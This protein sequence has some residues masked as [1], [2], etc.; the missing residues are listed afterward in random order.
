MRFSD[1]LNFTIVE[2]GSF[3]LKVVSII[4]IVSFF[5]I[6]KVILYF[7]KKSLVK[8]TLDE[9][10]R[11]LSLFKLFK[12]FI[13]VFIIMSVFEISGINLTFLVA[14]SA[15][16]LIGIGLGLQQTF[17][18]FVSGIIILIEGSIKVGDIVEIEGNVGKVEDINLRTSK[19]YTREL[20]SII[21]PN[22]R[23]VTDNVINWSLDSRLR[24][25]N[26]LVGVAY[27]SDVDLVMQCM[28]KSADNHPK[29]NKEILE[30][31]PKVRL[32]NF[33]N[34]SLDFEL[35]FWSTDVFSI[36]FI[37]SE[38]RLDML[39]EFG[40]LGIVI[41]FPQQDIHVID[42]KSKIDGTQ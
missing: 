40:K 35:L 33:G 32:I 16:L 41:P 28:F 20:I 29:V 10:Q 31:V 14:G 30:Y 1:I 15:A 24:R 34:S 21:V 17:N 4:L 7:V 42:I 6:A 2:Y 23:F 38:I 27:G 22:H 18:D 3:K 9:K 13:W 26:I 19:I 25:F 12:Y 8:G 37:K 5:F 39:K 11:R 36:E